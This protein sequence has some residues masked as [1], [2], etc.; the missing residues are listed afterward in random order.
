MPSACPDS[1]ARSIPRRPLEFGTGTLPP[2]RP[3]TH[4]T[5]KARHRSGILRSRTGGCS[6]PHARSRR[7]SPGFCLSFS[8][9]RFWPRR[10]AAPETNSIRRRIGQTVLE[11]IRTVVFSRRPTTKEHA[12]GLPAAP[13]RQPVSGMNLA[14]TPL[15][16]A[17]GLPPPARALQSLPP[18]KLPFPR[19]NRS[20]PAPWR[21]YYPLVRRLA[22][23]SPAKKQNTPNTRP[24]IHRQMSLYRMILSV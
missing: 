5:A 10:F 14:P 20:N 15:I 22:L 23:Q 4:V 16:S 8:W 3:S 19:R 2:P 9:L 11:T 21:R 6:C 12:C 24:H 13:R 18:S 1:R 7:S 17:Y